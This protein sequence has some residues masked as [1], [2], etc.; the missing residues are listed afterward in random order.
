MILEKTPFSLLICDFVKERN[1]AWLGETFGEHR[2]PCQFNLGS[3][4]GRGKERPERTNAETL[5]PSGRAAA[6]SCSR[7]K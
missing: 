6:I 3:G 4:A 5:C 2:T 7:A 1:L